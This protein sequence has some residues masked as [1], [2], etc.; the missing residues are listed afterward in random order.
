MN[1][2]R[3]KRFVVILTGLLLLALIL[4]EAGMRAL[5]GLGNPVL[6]VA[7]PKM[8]YIPAPNQSVMRMGNRIEYNQYSMRSKPF[9]REK[10]EGELRLMVLGDSVINGGIYEDQNDLAT[11]LIANALQEKLDK[12]IVVGNISAGS[13][14]PPNLLAYVDEYGF[15]DA[16]YVF[17]VLSSHDY[18]DVPTYRK[19]D[20]RYFPQ[21]KPAS[22]FSEVI[23]NYVPRYFPAL[24]RLIGEE[25][26]QEPQKEKQFY[27]KVD[28]SLGALR[29]LLIK[30]KEKERHVFALQHVEKDEIGLSEG[31]L[32]HDHFQPV[33]DEL[34]VQ[35][36]RL[37]PVFESSLN[38]GKNAYRDHIH[39]NETGQKLIADQIIGVVLSR[40]W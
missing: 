12:K 9:E 17:V 11:T 8:E 1:R 3:L 16:D 22:A 14:G 24:L 26:A 37:A 13:W 40:E 34:G 25:I 21:E 20:P 18:Y 19:L 10:A 27:R 23:F 36:I 28:E 39:P 29:N 30:A 33:C 31:Y 7:H 38:A 6:Y 5:F 15:F 2:A 4:T 32:G 35:L